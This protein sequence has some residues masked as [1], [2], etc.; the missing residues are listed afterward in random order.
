[1]TENQSKISEAPLSQSRLL[2]GGA[3]F[4]FGLLC[5]LFIPLVTASNLPTGWKVT[6]SGLLALGIPELFALIA[7]ALLG[8]AGFNYLKGRLFGWFKR[9]APPDAV[10]RTRYRIGLVMFVLPLIAGWLLPYFS[11]LIPA[12]EENRLTVNIGGDLLF[13]SSFFVLGG[14]FWDKV[15][16][17][18]IHGAKAQ[19]PE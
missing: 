5:P 11:H 19:F 12:F 17:L 10:S 4:I 14:D 13:L 3:I 18:F 15:R 7:A 1:M 2:C 9:F 8:K 16:A 6:I